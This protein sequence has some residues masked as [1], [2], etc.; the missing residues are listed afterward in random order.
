MRAATT[1]QISHVEWIE[2]TT[3]TRQG[4][5]KKRPRQVTQKLMRTGGPHCPVAY[6]EKLLSKRPPELKSAGPL[7]L[8]CENQKIGFVKM[9][10]SLGNQWESIQSTTT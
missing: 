6:F 1:G 7:Y 5:L 8:L 10:G 9:C 2:G 3:E 4:G